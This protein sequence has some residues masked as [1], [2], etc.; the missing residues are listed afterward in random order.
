MT[1]SGTS[2]SQFPTPPSSTS[3]PRTMGALLITQD[4][5][6][7]RVEELLRLLEEEDEEIRKRN[8]T[9]ESTDEAEEGTEDK[10]KNEGAVEGKAKD[11]QVEGEALE[12]PKSPT[13]D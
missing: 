4:L 5:R 11:K 10:D 1:S 9:D 6:H 13:Q 2:L 7:Q 12:D 3:T 8:V